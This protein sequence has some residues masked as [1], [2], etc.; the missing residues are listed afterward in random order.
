MTYQNNLIEKL[1][2][3]NTKYIPAMNGF[4][5][6][7][8]VNKPRCTLRPGRPR[9]TLKRTA[10]PRGV[11]FFLK[12]RS[13]LRT[14]Y[15]RAP[16]RIFSRIPPRRRGMVQFSKRNFFLKNF[17][18][19]G[20]PP[21]GPSQQEIKISRRAGVVEKRLCCCC[22]NGPDRRRRRRR[23]RQRLRGNTR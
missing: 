3:D 18:T 7:A 23:R 15:F 9:T 22:E 5:S 2:L 11:R 21:R 16:E 20:S 13:A 17:R 14:F 8:A 6:H 19:T 4:Y 10:P 12:N 1:N